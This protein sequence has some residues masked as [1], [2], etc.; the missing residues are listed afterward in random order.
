MIQKETDI[1]IKLAYEKFEKLKIIRRH[2]DVSTKSN[3]QRYGKKVFS[4]LDWMEEDFK[5]LWRGYKNED[6]QNT[7][8]IIPLVE[9]YKKF[10]RKIPESRF[11]IYKLEDS[12]R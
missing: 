8:K 10:L 9:K 3:L 1:Q 2:R 6:P 7:S 11:L 4:E 12:L 5:T